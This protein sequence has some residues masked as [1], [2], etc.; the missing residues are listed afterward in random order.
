MHKGLSVLIDN[1]QFR[2]QLQLNSTV[3]AGGRPV[4]DET[5]DGCEQLIY[6]AATRL[7][8][9]LNSWWEPERRRYAYDF[10]DTH[11]CKTYR[12]NS[13]FQTIQVGHCPR[14]LLS[15]SPYPPLP[16]VFLVPGTSFPIKSS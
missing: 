12:G 15:P 11:G 4:A 1:F 8:N 6:K 9:G 16:F 13:N 2:F 3:V 5:R 14:Y 7:M 10:D